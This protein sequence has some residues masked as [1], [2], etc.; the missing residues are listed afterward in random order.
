M[1]IQSATVPGRH[2]GRA[3]SSLA[4]HVF[5]R[6]ASQPWTTMWSKS[7][8]K[9]ILPSPQNVPQTSEDAVR[10]FKQAR[11]ALF[12][13]VTR[14]K[15]LSGADLFQ[16]RSALE[17]RLSRIRPKRVGEFSRSTRC[18]Q[19]ASKIAFGKPDVGCWRP[20][21]RLQDPIQRRSAARHATASALGTA[22]RP[23]ARG[24]ALPAPGR[25]TRARSYCVTK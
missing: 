12:S 16:G 2:S 19:E 5:S 11:R 8:C 20:S 1:P 6:N 21:R 24:V 7:R 23:R 25:S 15:R 18:G 10:A 13:A 3:P 9:A 14:F 22:L 17:S 4:S